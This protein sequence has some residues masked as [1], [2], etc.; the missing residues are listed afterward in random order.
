MNAIYEYIFAGFMMFVMLVALHTN[1]QNLVSDTTSLMMQEE[2]NMADSLADMILLS[3]GNPPNWSFSN[4][5]LF[6]LAAQETTQTYVLDSRK[7][8]RLD[9]KCANY[10]DY[11]YISTGE[12][13]SLLGL[14]SD[15]NLVIRMT[16]IFPIS[17]TSQGNGKYRIVVTNHRN[18]TLANVNVTGY[19]VPKYQG[20]NGNWTSKSSITGIDGSCTLDFKNST[21]IYIVVCADLIGVK[22]MRT[23]PDYLKVRVEEGQVVQS[24]V[25]LITSINYTSGLFYG[26]N[27]DWATRYVEIDGFTYYFELEVWR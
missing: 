10:T 13:R 26:L 22:S 16:P 14:T 18:M 3:P 1:L 8:I 9:E 17:I 4:P 2:Y 21:D 23:S 12:I 19:C 6:G 27:T 11:S 20:I 7:V 25:P 5:I 24:E 15:I